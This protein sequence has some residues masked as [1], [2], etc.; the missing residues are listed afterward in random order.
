MTGTTGEQQ[1]TI[2]QLA[3]KAGVT[4]RTIRYYTSE[5]LLPVPLRHGTYAIYGEEHLL[6]LQ[7]I[8]R[9]KAAYLP[10][11]EIRA[12]LER[13][14]AEQVRAQLAADPAAGHAETSPELLLVGP[15]ISE[16]PALGYKPATSYEQ[17]PRAQ[18]SGS[19]TMRTEHLQP[20]YASVLSQMVSSSHEQDQM[21]ET[22]ERIPI[23]PGIERHLLEPIT[24]RTRE[25]AA[26]LVEIARGLFDASSET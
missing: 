11:G 26:R 18:L 10:L 8:A 20:G 4:T 17:A 12:R 23:G 6:R 15:R 16:R 1:W 5:G 2:G 14:T 24:A 3:A 22:W 13:M 7:L 21:Q 9:L 25:Q 19:S